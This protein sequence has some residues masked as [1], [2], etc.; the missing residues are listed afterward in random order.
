MGF[1]ATPER[2]ARREV[3]DFAFLGHAFFVR[4]GS[5]VLRARVAKKPDGIGLFGIEVLVVMLPL[6]KKAQL[7]SFVDFSCEAAEDSS[8]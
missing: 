7:F 6:I 5:R 4:F 8:P 1:R 3:T 2:K